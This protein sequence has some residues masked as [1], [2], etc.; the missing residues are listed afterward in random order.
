MLDVADLSSSP[1]LPLF[2]LHAPQT[3]RLRKKAKNSGPRNALTGV[4]ALPEDFQSTTTARRKG[5][6]LVLSPSSPLPC[7]LF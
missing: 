6:H 3:P 4:D 2:Q 7:A 1:S 5:D